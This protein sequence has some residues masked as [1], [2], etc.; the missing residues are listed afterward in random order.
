MPRSATIEIH[1][2]FRD[3]DHHRNFSEKKAPKLRC[4]RNWG[5]ADR[6]TLFDIAAVAKTVSTLET[7][8]HL[9]KTQCIWYAL[10]VF[11]LIPPVKQNGGYP[12]VFTRLESIVRKVMKNGDITRFSAVLGATL[13]KHAQLSTARPSACEVSLTVRPTTPLPVASE[14][15]VDNHDHSCTDL[16]PVATAFATDLP[17]LA[18][19][20][21]VD[22]SP[23][24]TVAT[25]IF[26]TYLPSAME[27]PTTIPTATEAATEQQLIASPS[28]H[29]SFRSK[30][31]QFFSR[32]TKYDAMGLARVALSRS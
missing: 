17:P 32:P 31:K 24:A 19:T 13:R 18:T 12:M 28:S 25:T 27:S 29:A 6:P 9:Y 8:Y 26:S 5:D 1:S 3:Q 22:L 4:T 7:N 14:V 11:H 15:A 23:V 10:M 30:I 21:S 16:S 20:F 2:I